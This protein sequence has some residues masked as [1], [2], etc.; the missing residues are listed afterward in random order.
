MRQTCS[1]RRKSD[2]VAIA[3]DV[4]PKYLFRTP[5]GSRDDDE[6][7]MLNGYLN[8][9]EI[10]SD[11]T[12]LSIGSVIRI[13]PHVSRGSCTD[14]E[15]FVHHGCQRPGHFPGRVYFIADSAIK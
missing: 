12:F 13:L 14:D 2:E 1:Q 10:S 7:Y 3:A 9:A 8:K 5:C 6:V 15:V 4:V 11:D